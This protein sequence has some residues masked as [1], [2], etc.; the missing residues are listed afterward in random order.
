[1]IWGCR[2][3]RCADQRILT[4]TAHLFSDHCTNNFSPETTGSWGNILRA[5]YFGVW[6]KST[7]SYSAIC[8]SSTSSFYDD[9]RLPC[10]F[11]NVSKIYSD[12]CWKLAF[13]RHNLGNCDKYFLG[14]FPTLLLL[15]AVSLNVEKSNTSL[16]GRSFSIF[17][18]FPFHLHDGDILADAV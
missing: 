5:S 12:N 16:V 18:K 10:W 2:L 13:N 1:M 4:D 8:S 14:V 17:G 11:D 15:T 3:T 6:Q 9:T 7:V